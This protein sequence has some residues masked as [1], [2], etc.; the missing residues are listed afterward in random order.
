MR[1]ITKSLNLASRLILLCSLFCGMLA[2]RAPTTVAAQACTPVE[3][4]VLSAPTINLGT[5]TQFIGGS[6]SWTE[7][8]WGLQLV[9]SAYLS[10]TS[11]IDPG[12]AW[13]GELF[14]EYFSMELDEEL[15]YTLWL[16]M[17]DV[18]LTG[19][20]SIASS[21]DLFEINNDEAVMTNGVYSMTLAGIQSDIVYIQL[22]IDGDPHTNF[23][24]TGT[25]K[26]AIVPQ[27]CANP[28]EPTPTETPTPTATPTATTMPTPTATPPSA[29]LSACDGVTCPEGESCDLGVCHAPGSRI[30]AVPDGCDGYEVLPSQWDLLYPGQSRTWNPNHGY[31][32]YTVRWTF[33]ADPSV[34]N[35]ADVSVSGFLLGLSW[36]GPSSGESLYYEV[37]MPAHFYDN[38]AQLDR[39]SVV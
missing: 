8:S 14:N 36:S 7:T 23:G 33:R 15:Y 5:N 16:S 3:L 6:V 26:L 22:A 29:G 13:I 31:N 37:T 35:T 21:F 20:A 38:P 10:A 32:E 17:S 39:K 4:N 19:S 12:S 2:W 28:M 11:A 1:A 27:G 30:L 18:A 25:W 9:A 24:I 34:Y